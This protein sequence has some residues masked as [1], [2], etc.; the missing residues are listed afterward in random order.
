M[1]AASGIVA[2]MAS[3]S[4][5]SMVLLGCVAC[6]GAQTEAEPAEAPTSEIAESEASGGGEEEAAATASSDAAAAPD[7]PPAEKLEGR[8]VKYIMTPQ[9]LEVEVAGVRFFTAAKPIQ[10]GGGWGVR[11]SATAKVK[12]DKSHSLLSPKNGPIAF[13][14]A[15]KR[16]G[17]EPE[18]F[19]DKREGDGEETLEPGKPHEIKRDFPGKDGPKPLKAGD[20]LELEV[21]LW[22]LGDNAEARKAVRAF[23]TVKMVV[24][25]G[26]PQPV[27]SPPATATT[28]AE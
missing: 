21:G 28:S 4:L 26:K 25:K 24:G 22:G 15:V 27:I 16:G 2:D 23:F 11:L 5:T 13:A 7:E 19:S 12:D 9:G 6:G 1:G 14:A 20:E 18:R 17:G 10:M 3:R 8:E